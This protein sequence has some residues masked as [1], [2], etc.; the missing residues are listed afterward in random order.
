MLDAEL[1]K[2]IQAQIPGAPEPPRGRMS[3]SN[4]FLSS[5]HYQFVHLVLLQVL[6]S[7]S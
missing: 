2:V 6:I 7:P 1:E 3:H 4:S 5:L